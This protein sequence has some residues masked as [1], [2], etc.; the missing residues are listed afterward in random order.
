MSITGQSRTDSSLHFQFAT[1]TLRNFLIST[2]TVVLWTCSVSSS[3]KLSGIRREIDG[4]QQDA[5]EAAK[6]LHAIEAEIMLHQ[7][8]TSEL[9]KAIATADEAK[10]IVHQTIHLVLNLPFEDAKPDVDIRRADLQQLSDSQRSTLNF[11]TRTILRPQ[12]VRLF[13]MV[14][15]GCGNWGF[16]QTQPSPHRDLLRIQQRRSRPRW[17]DLFQ[18]SRRFVVFAVMPARRHFAILLASNSGSVRG[19][20][21]RRGLQTRCGG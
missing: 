12:H 21:D 9:S 15:T 11:K 7:S 14:N 2:L 17:R 16:P 20:G 8:P 6:T 18:Q 1:V 5:V 10:Q 3:T 19:S 4:T 13:Q